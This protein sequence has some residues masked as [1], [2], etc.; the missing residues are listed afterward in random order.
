MFIDKVFKS[1][2]SKVFK[3]CL[4]QNLHSKLLTTVNQLQRQR[5]KIAI[6]SHHRTQCAKD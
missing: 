3:D 2:L 1:G 4:P 6:L 5:Y